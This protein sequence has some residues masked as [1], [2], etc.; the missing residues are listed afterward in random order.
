MKK[1]LALALLSLALRHEAAEAQRTDWSTV[2][3]TPPIGR[4]MET[5][6]D[7]RARKRADRAT[8]AKADSLRADVRGA[9]VTT[10]E[11][12]N[13]LLAIRLTFSDEG[14]PAEPNVTGYNAATRR[15][16]E[17][18]ASHLRGPWAKADVGIDGHTDNVGPYDENLA[19]SLRRA[20]AIGG[21]LM[22]QGVDSARIA[23]RGLSYDYP[24]A[25]N[26]LID[27]RERNR[28]VEI[29]LSVS[30]EMLAEMATGR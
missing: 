1:T 11:D 26:H 24:L 16:V 22:R 3:E 20:L 13:G 17:A 8:R 12:V 4:T 5:P 28:R 19:I 14:L 25:D 6:P 9:A 29:T 30:T 23:T 10:A 7:N 18:L 21:L 15:A 2:G 27:G